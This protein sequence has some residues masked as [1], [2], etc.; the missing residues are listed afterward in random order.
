MGAKLVERKE[1]AAVD[2]AACVEAGEEIPEGAEGVEEEERREWNALVEACRRR[3]LAVS[4][5]ADSDY[6]TAEVL[7]WVRELVES[8]RVEEALSE[9]EKLGFGWSRVIGWKELGRV[10]GVCTMDAVAEATSDGEPSVAV[11]AQISY[12]EDQPGYRRVEYS[13]V[14]EIRRRP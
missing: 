1:E 5:C 6:F 3:G 14:L 12:D 11:Y 7:R 13:D 4:G 9:V 8:G 2:A 10:S